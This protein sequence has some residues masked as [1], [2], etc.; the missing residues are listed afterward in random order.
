[1]N[2]LTAEDFQPTVTGITPLILNKRKW[3]GESFTPTEGRGR[4]TNSLWIRKS[5]VLPLYDQLFSTLPLATLIT[6]TYCAALLATYLAVQAT[7]F[8][9]C[10]PLQ[11]CWQVVPDPA[12]NGRKSRAVYKRY[13]STIYV[14]GSQ[15]GY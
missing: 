5:V 11:L 14:C 8:V 12:F 3:S 10:R 2:S 1:M 4:V 7:S 6:K 15:H 13:H 9:D